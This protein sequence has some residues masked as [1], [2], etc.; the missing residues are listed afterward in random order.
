MASNKANLLSIRSKM[1]DWWT[2][3]KRCYNNQL[4]L[5]ICTAVNCTVQWIPWIKYREF[6]WIFH[7]CTPKQQ[8]PFPKRYLNLNFSFST[9]TAFW[10]THRFLLSVSPTHFKMEDM[11]MVQT[12][13]IWKDGVTFMEQGNFQDALMNFMALEGRADSSQQLITSGRN[14]FNIGQTYLALGRMD[15][16]AKVPIV[17]K[18]TLFHR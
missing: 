9:S 3:C 16:A 14:L 18:H 6:R 1:V 17:L 10:V 12:L 7:C 15:M 2:V 11:S 4:S 8:Y 13:R 5:Q